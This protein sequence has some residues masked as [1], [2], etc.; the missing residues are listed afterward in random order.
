MKA[1]FFLSLIFYFFPTVFYKLSST[2][3]F[4]ILLIKSKGIGFFWEPD[5]SFTCF[6]FGKPGG[7]IGFDDHYIINFDYKLITDNRYNSIFR[8]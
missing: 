5:E 6:A 8:I 3:N 2:L 1:A 4:T 7:I